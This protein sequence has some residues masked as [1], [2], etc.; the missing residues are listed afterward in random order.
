[1]SRPWAVEPINTGDT[2]SAEALTA[3]LRRIPFDQL[4]RD[5]MGALIVGYSVVEV[6]WEAVDDKL[7]PLRIPV[8]RPRRFVYVDA[9]DSS[10]PQLR[11]L[12]SGDMLRGEALPARKFIVHR[13][14]PRDDNPYGTGLGLYLFWP[15]YFKRRGI[16]GWA[17]F[18]DRFGAPTPWGR[19]PNNAEAK[20]K[21]TL[22]DALRAFSNDGY[23]MTPEGAL[24]ELLEAGGGGNVTTQAELVRVMDS[25]IAEV[26]LGQESGM[27]SGGALAAAAKERADV[28]LDLV[29]ADSDLLSETLNQTLIKWICD[30]HGIGPCNVYRQIKEEVDRKV[31]SETDVNVASLG[32]ELSEEAARAK[33]GDGWSRREPPPAPEAAPGA[34]FAEPVSTAPERDAVD[35]LNLARLGA[36]EAQPV[37]DNWI[38]RIGSILSDHPD[39]SPDEFQ[40]LLVQIY[41][42]LPTGEL[43]E[44]MAK[45]YVIAE[46]RGMRDVEAGR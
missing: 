16:V 1:M 14:N 13:V 39:A 17:K 3:L 10:G 31:E 15:V 27:E 28:R 7:L 2:Q 4:C 33:Y 21:K 43:I 9:D 19:Y 41:G 24:I 37:L 34:R 11:L 26:I 46:Y 25:A 22:A 5:L 35:T 40:E 8:R 45:A 42:D 44:L 29:Q 38:E 12:T 20:D 23:I 18:C 36:A 32:F 6:I 30:F